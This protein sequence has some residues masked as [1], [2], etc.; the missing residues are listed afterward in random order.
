MKTYIVSTS[1]Q[2]TVYAAICKI[3]TDNIDSIGP[4]VMLA[5]FSNFVGKFIAMQIEDE[6]SIPD[7]LQIVTENMKIGNKEFCDKKVSTEGTVH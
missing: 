1:E 3:I 6:V 5:I 2:E 4:L 7:A